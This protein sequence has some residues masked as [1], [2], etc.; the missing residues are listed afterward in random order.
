MS[1]LLVWAFLI[2]DLA[3]AAPENIFSA[4][5]APLFAQAPRFEIPASMGVVEEVYQA[6]G[7]RKIYLIQDAHTNESC[8][9]SVS[10]LLEFL[11]QSQK[12]EY[13]FLEAGTGDNSLSYLR[14]KGSEAARRAVAHRWLQKGELKG[15]EHLDVASNLPLKLWGVED[16]KLYFESVTLYRA[17]VERRA[18]FQEYLDG[19]AAAVKA[20]KPLIYNPLLLAYDSKN[21]EYHAGKITATDYVDY[22]VRQASSYEIP[23]KEFPFIGALRDLRK[24]ESRIDFN[25]ANAQ[26]MKLFSALSS[27]DARE[28]EEA[29][30]QFKA[31][32]AFRRM[33]PESPGV[34]AFLMK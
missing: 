22:L 6:E 24:N 29:A 17:I 30:A 15:S 20:L 31:V 34:N 18:E 32:S 9:A 14:E 10:R 28:L 16:K 5:K 11:N 25:A 2:Q 4:G 21:R 7:Q 12:L 3:G 13:V 26:Q 33:S 8:Q 19:A 27:A 1:A 23:L